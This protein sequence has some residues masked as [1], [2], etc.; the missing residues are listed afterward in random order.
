M[1]KSLILSD[2]HIGSK[3]SQSEKILQVLSEVKAERIILVGDIIDG[4]LFQKYRRFSAGDIKVIRKLLKLSL[5]KRII[6]ISGNHDEFVREF[7]PISMGNMEVVD[8]YIDGNVWY[9]HGDAYDGVVKLKF[10]GKLGAF[11]YELSIFLD[12]IFKKL[13][14]KYSISKFLKTKTKEVVKF[15]T[16]FENE[17]VRQAKKRNINTVIC[18]HIHTPADKLIDNVRYINTGDWIESLSYVIETEDG[19]ELKTL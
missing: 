18:G 9:I 17:I 7:I 16:N 2:L 10:L 8:D 5:K 3:G 6:W 4:W 1:N 15:I 11:G 14:Y 12:G 13:G 19:F